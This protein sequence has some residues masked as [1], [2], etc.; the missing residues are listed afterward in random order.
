VGG[1][2]PT[3]AVAAWTRGC[4]SGGVAVDVPKTRSK[5]GVTSSGNSVFTVPER[6]GA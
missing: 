6:R 5:P 3:V 2:S 1:H 4:G